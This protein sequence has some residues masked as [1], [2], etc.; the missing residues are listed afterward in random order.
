MAT[1]VKKKS[2]GQKM[3][4]P[5]H[6]EVKI[7]EKGFA[8]LKEGCKMLIPTPRLI[9]DYLKHSTPGL[10]VDIKQIRTDLAAE[11]GADFTCPLTTG[12]FLRVL[13]EYTN[14]QHSAGMDL[15]NLAPVWRAIYPGL[16]VWKKLT[17][18]KKWL[19]DAWAKENLVNR[20]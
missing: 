1:S 19:E 13:T 15:K 8:D 11:N 12:I 5:A 7:L 6:P 2:W 18:D 4:K 16:P 14:E 20:G 9:E 3:D 17:F 10:R